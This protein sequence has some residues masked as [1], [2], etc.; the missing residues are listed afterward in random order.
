MSRAFATFQRSYWICHLK[1]LDFDVRFALS[2]SKNLILGIFRLIYEYYFHFWNAHA[3]WR[4]VILEFCKSGNGIVIRA[5]KN[6]RVT[7]FLIIRFFLS[8]LASSLAFWSTV[9]C[10]GNNTDHSKEYLLK[11]IAFH[12]NDFKTNK[13]N[14]SAIAI[15]DIEKNNGFNFVIAEV[16]EQEIDYSKR[17]IPEMLHIKND[18]TSHSFYLSTWWKNSLNIIVR[19]SINCLI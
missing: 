4:L 17:I 3:P 5:P 11:K 10:G 14:S 12:T 18:K 13:L 9:H 2:A 7:K 8:P 15:Y 16:L 6:P 19:A 1:F